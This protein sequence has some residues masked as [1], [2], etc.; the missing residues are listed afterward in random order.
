MTVSIF[1]LPL[2]A[3]GMDALLSGCVMDG[4]LVCAPAP[5]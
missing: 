2:N 4:I 1:S 5:L 3:Y